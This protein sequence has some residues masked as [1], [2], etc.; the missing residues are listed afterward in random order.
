MAEELAA[1]PRVLCHRDYHSRN[2]M[3][4][5]GRLYNIDIQDARM[6][7]DTYDLVSLLRDSYVD[8]TERDV[9]DLIAYFLA[10]RGGGGAGAAETAAFRRRFDLM[11]MQRN[12]KALG[13][14]GFQTTARGNPVYI[15][16]IPRTLAYVRANMERGGGFAR[17]RELLA[18]YIEELR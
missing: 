8:F 10:L 14:F 17:L 2:L 7:P 4:H 5:D 15:Q 12:L 13:T 9:D 6:G 16:Y 11:A 3:M 1:E 18:A